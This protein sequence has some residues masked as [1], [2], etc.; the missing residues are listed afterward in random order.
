MR[1]HP[2]HRPWA[3]WRVEAPEPCRRR[4]GGIGTPAHECLAHG[5]EFRFGLP[6]HWVTP[7]Q[8][9]YY[10]GRARDVHGQPIGAE[11][12]GCGF[13]GVAIDPDDPPQYE[14]QAAYLERHGLLSAEERARLTAA[15]FEPDVVV[16][17]DNIKEDP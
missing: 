10:T 4:L 5:P 14:S 2:G 6:A 17:D 15:D 3:W 7:W 11:Y 12:R 16:I 9:A 1:A 8:V 13:S